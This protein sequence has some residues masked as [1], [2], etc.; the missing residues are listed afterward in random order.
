MVI[1]TGDQPAVD[2]FNLAHVAWDPLT[3][4]ASQL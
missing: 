3:W 1:T 4:L 2:E